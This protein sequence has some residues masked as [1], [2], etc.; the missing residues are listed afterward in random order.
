MLIITMLD[1]SITD[2]KFESVGTQIAQKIRNLA[3]A[4]QMNWPHVQTASATEDIKN[5]EGKTIGI[6]AWRG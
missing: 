6:I 1:D 4:V 3:L 2:G 5:Q